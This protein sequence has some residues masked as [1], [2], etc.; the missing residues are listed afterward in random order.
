ME[1]DMST[2][3]HREYKERAAPVYYLHL[4]VEPATRNKSGAQA[5]GVGW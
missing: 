5:V 2:D 4:G 1:H 3:S